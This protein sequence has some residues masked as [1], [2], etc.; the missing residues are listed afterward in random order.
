MKAFI[1]YFNTGD[2]YID[3]D[4]GLVESCQHNNA[5]IYNIDHG[6]NIL[7]AVEVLDILDLAT[8]GRM[9]PARIWRVTMHQG[10]DEL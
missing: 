8:S 4:N 7:V 5:I 2:I 3:L 9:T 6:Q 1:V 10:K